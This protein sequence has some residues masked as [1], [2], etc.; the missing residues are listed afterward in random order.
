MTYT[1]QSLNK[2]AADIDGCGIAEMESAVAAVVL[3]ARRVGVCPIAV[4]VLADPTEPE[5]V[6][7]RAFGIVATH[8]ARVDRQRTAAPAA[9]T[10]ATA[11]TGR[12]RPRVLLEAGGQPLARCAG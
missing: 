8:L 3:G 7:E 5:V 10:S 4:D 9:V 1:H 6:R 11:P 2:L 12:S